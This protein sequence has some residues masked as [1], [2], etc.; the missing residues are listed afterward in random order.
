MPGT[1]YADAYKHF[2]R[3][4]NIFVVRSSNESRGI[5]IHSTTTLWLGEFDEA[6]TT[7]FLLLEVLLDTWQEQPVWNNPSPQ[8]L[9]AL[10]DLSHRPLIKTSSIRQATL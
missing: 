4:P 7:C 6:E 10:E 3:V 9:W 1:E 2:L 8:P 5:W